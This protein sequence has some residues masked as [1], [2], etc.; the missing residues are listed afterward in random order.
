MRIHIVR[1]G[2]FANH[3]SSVIGNT[4]TLPDDLRRVV[5]E[6]EAAP[7]PSPVR[8]GFQYDVTLERDDG[9][10]LTA[11]VNDPTSVAELYSWL[12][13]RAT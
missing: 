6:I 8:D 10:V 2:G 13:K 5:E 3:Q 1:S 4:E 7:G 11:T 12:A 9:S